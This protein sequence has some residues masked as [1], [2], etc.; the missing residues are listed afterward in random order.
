[1]CM[2]VLTGRGVVFR[3]RNSGVLSLE[4]DAEYPGWGWGVFNLKNT[5]GNCSFN[6]SQSTGRKR[7]MKTK[8]ITF[9][10]KR[11]NTFTQEKRK[12]RGCWF[13]EGS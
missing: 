10:S 6:G 2:M 11:I 8:D 5:P 1:M 7:T 4:I 9:S 12:A 13:C 3:N